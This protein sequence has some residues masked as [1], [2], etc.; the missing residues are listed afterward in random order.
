MRL[1]GGLA[2]PDGSAVSGRLEVF[3]GG[4]WGPVCSHAADDDYDFEPFLPPAAAGVACR[5][6]GFAH[7]FAMQPVVRR[8]RAAPPAATARSPPAGIT[9]IT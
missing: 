5:Q 3:F 7:S 9:A 8:R 1:T 6:L 4:G 2:A